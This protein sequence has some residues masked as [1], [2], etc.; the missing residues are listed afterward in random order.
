MNFWTRTF[1]N[2]VIRAY[3]YKTKNYACNGIPLSKAQTCLS[4]LRVVVY[5]SCKLVTRRYYQDSSHENSQRK[6]STFATQRILKKLLQGRVSQGE[7][8][9]NVK[10]YQQPACKETRVHLV[11]LHHPWNLKEDSIFHRNRP[12]LT[13][14]I[15]VVAWSHLCRRQGSKTRPHHPRCAHNQPKAI[16]FLACTNLNSCRLSKLDLRF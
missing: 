4:N 3:R 16:P 2:I 1:S 8:L 7:R 10:K 5:K 9:R 14:L 12:R 15:S 11:A 13:T 6:S